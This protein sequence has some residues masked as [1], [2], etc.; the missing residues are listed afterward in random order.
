[1]FSSSL[2]CAYGKRHNFIAQSGGGPFE[3]QQLRY[4]ENRITHILIG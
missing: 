3:C 1:M 4:E 2:N